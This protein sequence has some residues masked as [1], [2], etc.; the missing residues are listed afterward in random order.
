MDASWAPSSSICDAPPRQKRKYDHEPLMRA[1]KQFRKAR[2]PSYQTASPQSVNKSDAVLR[3]LKP[4]WERMSVS[5]NDAAQSHHP[6]P[7]SVADSH[8]FVIHTVGSMKNGHSVDKTLRSRVSPQTV[9][10]S[11]D[12]RSCQGTPQPDRKYVLRP[13][14]PIKISDQVNSDI[15]QTILGYCEPKLLLEARTINS[16]FYRLLNDRSG[17]WRQCRRTHF[18]SDMPDC[19]V[20]LTEQQYVDLLVGRGCQSR[21]CPKERT[22]RVYWTFQ[23]RLCAECFKQKTMRVSGIPQTSKPLTDDNQEDDL[24]FHRRHSVP[25]SRT[26]GSGDTGSLDE[27]SLLWELLPL[28]RSDR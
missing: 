18:G 24:P 27:G 12:Q 4:S 9:T 5:T 19:P 6:A 15:W 7:A 16:T 20:G 10:Q 13:S 25:A 22:A 21:A 28:A 17:I 11:A 3:N 26:R 1:E 23:V 8:I 2:Q 14:R